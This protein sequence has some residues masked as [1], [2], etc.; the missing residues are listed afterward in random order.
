[1]S[2]LK[3]PR[4]LALVLLAVF[5]A[6]IAWYDG[7]G[8]ALSASEIESYIGRIREIA[9]SAGLTPDENLL[10]ELQQ[11]AASDDGKE[12]FMLNLIN[13]RAQ[14]VYPAGSRFSGTGL[15]ADA[16]YNQAIAPLLFKHG[17]HPVFLGTPMGRFI[18]VP[19]DMEWQR[20]A[21][22]RYRSRRDLLE[23]VIDLA[24]KPI[25]IH[26]WASIEK[27]QVFPVRSFFDLIQ[28]RGTVAAVLT[29]IGGLLHLLLRR[30]RF[31]SGTPA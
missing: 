20:I 16:R 14:A 10:R 3:G 9:K 26:K 18:D 7:R 12:F 31:Y 25:G 29:V 4:L 30:C 2:F 6:F 15:E 11:L 13:Y 1:M 19:G 24:A 27:T 17:N 23:M 21:I 28:T 5:A 22:V 8:P